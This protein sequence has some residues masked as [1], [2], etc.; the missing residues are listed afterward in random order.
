MLTSQN[1]Q[2]LKKTDMHT[3]QAYLSKPNKEYAIISSQETIQN[4]AYI[5]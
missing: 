3:L 5:I 1:K 4:Y 2:F